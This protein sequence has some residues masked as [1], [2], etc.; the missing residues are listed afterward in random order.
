MKQSILTALVVS[1]GITATAMQGARA[2]NDSS[3][4]SEALSLQ[5]A[6]GSL[7]PVAAPSSFKRRPALRAGR[8]R[9]V[10]ILDFPGQ[11]CDAPDRSCR[12]SLAE[13]M[14]RDLDIDVF[15]PWRS[16]WSSQGRRC[17]PHADIVR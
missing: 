13:P 15:A 3:E 12:T 2:E 4:A 7:Q 9:C 17:P 10:I 8:Q 11:N 6:G 14:Q 5:N 1:A 16:P